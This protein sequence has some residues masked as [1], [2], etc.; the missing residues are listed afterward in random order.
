M[1]VQSVNHRQGAFCELSLQLL[2]F[3]IRHLT[4]N[5]FWVLKM[6]YVIILGSKARVGDNTMH[7]YI[8]LSRVRNELCLKLEI[9]SKQLRQM[10]AAWGER[11]YSNDSEPLSCLCGAQIRTCFMEV[12][13]LGTGALPPKNP[14]L[15]PTS[16]PFSSFPHN[17]TKQFNSSQGV[18]HGC[19]T[20]IV[21]PHLVLF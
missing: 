12:Y 14:Q 2:I 19:N 7:P 16:W 18:T 21:Y 9:V 4:R 1:L 6:R 8:F 20:G 10:K 13:F 5:D 17:L 15:P 3:G 11:R